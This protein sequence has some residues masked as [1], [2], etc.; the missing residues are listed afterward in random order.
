MSKVE[1]D[2]Y[3]FIV[4]VLCALSMKSGR[5]NVRSGDRYA[6]VKWQYYAFWFF[7]FVWVALV[8]VGNVVPLNL[9]IITSRVLP[10]IEKANAT[11]ATDEHYVGG[12]YTEKFTFIWATNIVVLP[13]RFVLAMVSFAY[14]MAHR[15]KRMSLGIFGIVFILYMVGEGVNIVSGGLEWKDANK[16]PDGMSDT[17]HER[18][19]ANSYYYCCKYGNMTAY[20]PNYRPGNTSLS[21][22]GFD[23]ETELQANEDFLTVYAIALGCI[24]CAFI[25]AVLGYSGREDILVVLKTADGQDVLVDYNT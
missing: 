24:V 8:L 14:L 12:Y 3:I 4:A 7:F 13:L 9:Q 17:K 21:C 25:M 11:S 20:C 6:R 16:A 19:I 2:L 15:K 18:N 10:L 22:Y 23:P 1:T 5:G